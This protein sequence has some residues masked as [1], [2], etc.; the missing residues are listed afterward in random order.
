MKRANVFTP[1][2]NSLLLRSGKLSFALSGA[3]VRSHIVISLGTVLKSTSSV[4]GGESQHPSPAAREVSVLMLLR[5]C[6]NCCGRRGALETRALRLLL[7]ATAA[8]SPAVHASGFPPM[9]ISPHNSDESIR[10]AQ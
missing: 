1:F 9:L 3:A 5:Y 6:C 4:I 2:C 8:E 7:G 10:R